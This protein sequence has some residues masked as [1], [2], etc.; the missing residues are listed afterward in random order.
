[1]TTQKQIEAN[2]QN[3]QLST[4]PMSAEGK[5]VV[6]TNAVKHGIFTKILIVSTEVG[7]ESEE[8]YQMLLNNLIDSLLPCNQM[9]SLLVEK[10]AVDFWRL[11]RTIGFETS[12]IAKH[13]AT[14]VKEFYSNGTKDNTKIDKEILYNQQ[15]IE[16]NTRYIACLN[17]GKVTFDE[18]VWVEDTFDSDIIDDLYRI[19]KSVN[20]L[21]EKDS[22]LIY[23]SVCLTLDELHIILQK[24]GYND[25]WS[26]SSKLIEIYTRETRRLEE[27]NEKL[28]Q[29][30]ISNDAADRLTYMFGMTPATENCDKVLKYERS[31]QKSI[32]QNLLLLKKLQGIF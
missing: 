12:S 28:S 20:K 17:Q 3:A 5:A 25:F 24:Y 11:R 13:I 19:A 27:A 26:I 21:S 8:E 15:V 29:E 18:T 22:T 9:E 30:K 31:L 2:Y 6:A 4:G 10:I 14:L 7:H 1:M 32:F 23:G 16:W